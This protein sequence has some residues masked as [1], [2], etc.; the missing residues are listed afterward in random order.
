MACRPVCIRGRAAGGGG[1]R[2]RD[3][4][5]LVARANGIGFANRRGGANPYA[6]LKADGSFESYPEDFVVPRY[7]PAVGSD[8]ILQVELD[9]HG[10]KADY[11]YV[12][13]WAGPK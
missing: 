6:V 5:G 11:Q 9:H 2:L 10:N 8:L 1:Q 7:D 13:E 4:R 3:G 12:Y